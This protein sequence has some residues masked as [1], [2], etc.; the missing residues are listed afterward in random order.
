[1]SKESLPCCFRI[2]GV[3]EGELASWVRSER[4]RDKEVGSDLRERERL[5]QICE[6]ERE[7]WPC[8]LGRSPEF[9]HEER[10]SGL[11]SPDM[12]TTCLD[13]E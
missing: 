9:P 1:M 12:A 4:E 7:S 11:C 2:T 3:R 10:S 5:D 6:R 13:G 8:S